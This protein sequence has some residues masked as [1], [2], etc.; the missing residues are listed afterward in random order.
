MKAGPQFLA[1]ERRSIAQDFHIKAEALQW[2]AERAGLTA[3]DAVAFGDMPNDLG[4]LTWAGCGVAMANAHAAVLAVADEI[5]T[6]NDD[7]GVARVIE[8]ILLG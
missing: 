5:T 2:I 7:D 8:R 3:A 4:M 6:S 1:S